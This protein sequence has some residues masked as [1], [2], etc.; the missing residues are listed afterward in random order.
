MTVAMAAI[1]VAA[2]TNMLGPIRRLLELPYADKLGHFALYG[3]LAWLCVAALVEMRP[4]WGRLR[5]VLWGS[6]AVVVLASAEEASQLFFKSRTFSLLDLA[7]SCAGILSLA[8][9]G[10]LFGPGLRR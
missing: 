8:A 10:V 7:A 4:T 1:V 5:V 9:I 2:D 3:I 6:L